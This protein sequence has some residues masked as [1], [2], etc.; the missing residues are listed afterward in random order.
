ML[1]EDLYINPERYQV[2]LAAK[3]LM[4]PKGPSS[5]PTSRVW[6]NRG[7]AY[8]MRSDGTIATVTSIADWLIGSKLLESGGFR[9]LGGVHL[10]PT[11]AGR[12]K[13]EDQLR[14]NAK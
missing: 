9:A 13:L 1:T 14:R 5:K 2:L 7:E 10:V 4:G 11:E 8:M 3:G 6:R 12:I